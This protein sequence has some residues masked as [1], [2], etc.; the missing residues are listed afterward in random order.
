MRARVKCAN[1]VTDTPGRA[2]LRDQARF[3]C[4][5]EGASHCGLPGLHSSQRPNVEAPA[6]SAIMTIAASPATLTSWCRYSEGH[7]L[8]RP[9]PPRKLDPRNGKSPW[10]Q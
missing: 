6:W 3:A 7:C 1:A 5:S 4:A 2:S 9:R 10:T 8:Q